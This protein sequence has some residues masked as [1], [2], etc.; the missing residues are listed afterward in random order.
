M[1]HSSCNIYPW[2]LRTA[3]T[4]ISKSLFKYMF[5]HV[6][7]IRKIFIL[8]LNFIYAIF[9]SRLKAIQKGRESGITLF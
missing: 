1:L 6:H 7:K 8:L 3:I 2:N 5:F 4:I 9:V